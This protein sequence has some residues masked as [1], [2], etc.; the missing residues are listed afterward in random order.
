MHITVEDITEQAKVVNHR[1]QSIQPRARPSK[2]EKPFQ[3]TFNVIS[4][5]ILE[6]VQSD[7][8][9]DLFFKPKNIELNST[10]KDGSKLKILDF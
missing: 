10:P 1:S 7:V 6:S 5:R 9:P 2:D 4:D 8:K 3:K